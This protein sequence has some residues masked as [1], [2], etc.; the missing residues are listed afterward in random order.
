MSAENTT[1]GN[2]KWLYIGIGVVIIAIAFYFM[3]KNKDTKITLSFDGDVDIKPDSDNVEVKPEGI[4]PLK[5][6]KSGKE[7]KQLQVYILKKYGV[8]L[9]QEVM[10][11]WDDVTDCI[12][13]RVMN[14]DSVS[15][16]FYRKTGMYKIKVG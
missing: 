9:P 10:G 4:F 12:V 11:Q 7:V 13:K 15:E 5:K 16:N 1:K 6:G 14:K 8:S 3:K 2:F